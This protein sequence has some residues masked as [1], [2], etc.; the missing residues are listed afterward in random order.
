MDEDEPLRIQHRQYFHKEIP[1]LV[2][3]SKWL[4]NRELRPHRKTLGKRDGYRWQFEQVLL[5]LQIF[6]IPYKIQ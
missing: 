4:L 5:I 2:G 3:I 1:S 6:G